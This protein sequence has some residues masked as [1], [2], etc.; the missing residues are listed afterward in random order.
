MTELRVLCPQLRSLRQASRLSHVVCLRQPDTEGYFW[1]DSASLFTVSAV[2]PSCASPWSVYWTIN[3]IRRF[4]GST[5]FSGLRRSWSAKPRTCAT[6]LSPSP[7]AASIA[8]PN[9][10]DQLRAP[11]CRSSSSR[12]KAWNPCDPRWKSYWAVCPVRPLADRATLR[13]SGSAL[14]AEIKK[15]PFADS[16]SSIRSPS[17]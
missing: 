13:R 6:C 16:N 3:E 14:A 12:Y 1:S 2:L 15:V 4:D 8:A 17:G 5:G 9:S 10:R 7:A 11:N